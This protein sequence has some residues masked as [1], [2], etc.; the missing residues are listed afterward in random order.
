MPMVPGRVRVQGALRN[1]T[2]TL[3]ASPTL[4]L[5]L[6][7]GLMYRASDDATVQVLT[8]ASDSG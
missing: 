4:I 6:G 7:S 2:P 1:V 5:V 3:T 8:H